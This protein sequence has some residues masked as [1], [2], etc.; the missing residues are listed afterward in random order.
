VVSR[1]AGAPLPALLFSTLAELLCDAFGVLAMVAMGLLALPESAS[2]LANIAHHWAGPA[3]AVVALCFLGV[4]LLGT[5][6]ARR[7][8]LL[9][10][11]GLPSRRARRVALRGFEA[12]VVG[13]MPIGSV[14][15]LALALFWTMAGWG[16]WVV[17]VLSAAACISLPVDPT[18]ALA[19]VCALAVAM[20]VPQAPGFLGG[21]QVVTVEVLGAFGA[22]KVAAD[23]MAVLLWAAFFLPVTVLGVEAAWRRGVRLLAGEAQ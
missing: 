8:A 23:A 17:A 1:H 2:G 11:R 20:S 21:F 13:L 3:V 12:L 6:R 5:R 16:A 22:P 14:R 10:S 18:A 15:R 7:A 9:L 4:L 19:L